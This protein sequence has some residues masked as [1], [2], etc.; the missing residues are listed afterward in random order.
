[1]SKI[2][3]Q[4]NIDTSKN[5]NQNSGRE[6]C[7]PTKRNTTFI[8]AGVAIYSAEALK[9]AEADMDMIPIGFADMVKKDT[10]SP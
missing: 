3:K 7:I 8:G 9:K 10:P 4:K 5:F 2:E 6:T 1:M